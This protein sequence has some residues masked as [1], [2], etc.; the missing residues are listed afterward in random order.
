MM[1]TSSPS[2]LPSSPS[3]SSSST[4]PTQ[5]AL[6]VTGLS[7]V[8]G[9]RTILS[10][11]T[12]ACAD[13]GILVVV[14]RSGSGK[15]VLWKAIAGL[16]PRAAG[17]VVVRRAPLVFVHQDPSL[18]EDRSVRDNLRLAAIEPGRSERPSDD[19]EGISVDDALALTATTS[20]AHRAASS[21]TPSQARRV[22]LA[23]ALVRRPGILVV[24]E[25]TTGLDP[26]AA[27]DVLEAILHLRRARPQ[28]AVVVITH[29]P[30]TRRALLSLPVS[31]EVLVYDGTIEY[32]PSTSTP[33]LRMG[34][35]FPPAPPD[36]LEVT[37]TREGV[38]TP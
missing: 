29:H 13:G 24:D 11:I 33:P 26:G 31:A 10:D 22:A 23:R 21:L 6:E 34:D 9:G 30:R 14:G 38:K 32:R 5:S 36:H 8:L 18:L 7:V 19:I 20:L 2:P 1:P 37:G 27:H 25:P 35:S 16:L 12:L 3:S 17:S 15:S 4:A 28:L